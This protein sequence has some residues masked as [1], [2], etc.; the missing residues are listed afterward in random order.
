VLRE[1]IEILAQLISPMLPHIAEAMWAELGHTTPLC[2][3][4]WPKAEASLLVDDTVTIAV[5]VN[6][7]LRAT[8][9]LPRDLAAQEAEHHALADAGVQRAL[10]GTTPRKIIVVPN[11]I[12]NIVA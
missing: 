9:T 2:E 4:L 10:A 5:Q 8:I 7:K 1:G 3:T 12:V 11:K 6:G